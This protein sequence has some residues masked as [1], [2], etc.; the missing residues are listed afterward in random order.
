MFVNNSGGVNIVFMY[1]SL[2]LRNGN[3]ISREFDKN[4]VLT[5]VV[6][7]RNKGEK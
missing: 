6:T 3:D 4:P 7:I 1:I 5:L 2:L